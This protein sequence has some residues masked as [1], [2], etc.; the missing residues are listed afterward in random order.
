MRIIAPFAAATFAVAF[1]AG[2]GSPAPS[3]PSGPASSSA[4]ATTPAPSPSVS[5]TAPG[6]G[7]EVSA[8]DFLK[9]VS[10]AEM[11]TY[12]M[13]M[14]MSTTVEGTP[15]TMTTSGSF[16]NSDTANPRSHMKMDIT[17]MEVEMIVVDGDAFIKM[18]MLGEDWMKM[19]PEDAAEMTGASGPDIGQWTEDYAK[20]VEKVELIGEEDVNGVATTQYRLTLKPE[21]LGDLGMEDAGVTMTDVVFDV[22]VDGDGFTR[23]FAMDM[24]GD[25]PVSMTATL[26]DINEP[27]T[28]E[29]PKDWVEM[30]S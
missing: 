21:A 9:R 4:P 23:K 14:E 29:A 24:A 6:G 10:G 27:V 7:S 17:G 5:T 12:T 1:L 28:I 16:D 3:A 15:M 19:D 2:C 20:N 8:D 18:A 13:D 30:P 26:D 22:W 25:V 11:K